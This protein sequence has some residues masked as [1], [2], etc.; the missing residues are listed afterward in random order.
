MYCTWTAI[1]SDKN[2]A[3]GGGGETCSKTIVRGKVNYGNCTWTDTLSG[4]TSM[5]Y[6]Y[7]TGSP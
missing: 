5:N 6:C 4:G 7:C 1:T 2:T 3:V